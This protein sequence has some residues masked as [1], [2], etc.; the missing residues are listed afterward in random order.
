M[1]ILKRLPAEIWKDKKNY[2]TLLDKTF[3]IKI[4]SDPNVGLKN[5]RF[6]PKGFFLPFLRWPIYVEWKKT[7]GAATCWEEDN[8]GWYD[9]KWETQKLFFL[10][11]FFF[12]AF[13]LFSKKWGQTKIVRKRPDCWRNEN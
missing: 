13:M 5:R 11:S 9:K 4:K 8:E 6:Y 3:Y 7:E 1:E 2:K 12:K 10:F